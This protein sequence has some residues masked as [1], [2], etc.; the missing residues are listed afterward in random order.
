MGLDDLIV[1]GSHGFDIWS[2][3]EGTIEHRGMVSVPAYAGVSFVLASP[4][5]PVGEGTKDFQ[6]PCR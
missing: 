5:S 3:D 2:P 1:A 6:S 4:I